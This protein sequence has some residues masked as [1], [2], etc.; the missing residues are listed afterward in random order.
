[1]IRIYLILAVLIFIVILC[2][3]KQKL[4][5]LLKRLS[6]PAVP[7]LIFIGL[8]FLMLTGK[9]NWLFGLLSLAV[10]VVLRMLPLL[11]RH[12]ALLQQLWRMM[13]RQKSAGSA[14]QENDRTQSDDAAQMSR[15]EAYQILGLSADATEEQ[16]IQAHRRLIQK[17]HPDRGGSDYL[18]AKINCAKKVL[19]AK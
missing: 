2:T 4:A 1:L 13:Q 18:A 3:D 10:A 8:G 11:L 6:K 9:L 17:I 15:Q 16:I 7:W 12:S 5:Q 19:L 14:R